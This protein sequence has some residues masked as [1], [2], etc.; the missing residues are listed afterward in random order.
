VPLA[1]HTKEARHEGDRKESPQAERRAL[2]VLRCPQRVAAEPRVSQMC[3]RSVC[4]AQSPWTPLLKFSQSMH[5]ARGDCM[6]DVRPLWACGRRLRSREGIVSSLAVI[7]GAR[8]PGYTEAE[9]HGGQALRLVRG[10]EGSVGASRWRHLRQTLTLLNTVIMSVPL[11]H[12]CG[13]LPPSA[14]PSGT[15]GGGSRATG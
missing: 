5:E 15:V 4:S 9:D 12:R 6:S 11:L 10:G 3:A 1:Y 8:V 7:H 2:L 14:W 13:R